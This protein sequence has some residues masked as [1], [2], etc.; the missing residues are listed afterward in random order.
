MKKIVIIL[1]M[2]CLALYFVGCSAGKGSGDDDLK[3]T[4]DTGTDNSETEYITVTVV[5]NLEA[6]HTVKVQTGGLADEKS[7][8]NGQCVNVRDL[9]KLVISVEQGNEVSQLCSNIDDNENNNCKG[10]YNIIYKIADSKTGSNKLALESTDRNESEDCMELFPVYTITLKSELSGRT[11]KVYNDDKARTLQ[12]KDSCLKLTNKDF[13]SFQIDVGQGD[14]NR[15]VMCDECKENNYE[16]S[17]HGQP[18]TPDEVILS[19]ETE[20]NKSKSCEWFDTKWLDF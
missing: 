9:E 14:E 4:T 13:S 10:N 8:S 1:S 15:Q 5:A 2:I 12:A 20:Y 11:V 18:P 6:G 17:L 7:L 16:I 19:S 3:G